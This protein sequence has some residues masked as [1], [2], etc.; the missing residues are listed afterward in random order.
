MS[1]TDHPESITYCFGQFA[2]NLAT[3]E[4]LHHGEAVELQ[5][6]VLDLLIYLLRNR[7]R[8]VDKQELQDAVWPRQIVTEAALTRCVMKARKALGDDAEQQRYIRTV[9]GTGYRLVT[10]VVET[11]QAAA[12]AR[13][14]LPPGSPPTLLR[15]AS[16]GPMWLSLL[17]IGIVL[18]VALIWL[19]QRQALEPT[20]DMSDAQIAIFPVT[21]ATGD[22]RYDWVTLGMMSSLGQ[23]LET[24]SRIRVVR[25]SQA[26]E[27]A[28][29]FHAG[30]GGDQ[31]LR[32]FAAEL[33][34]SDGI[35]LLVL[36][37]LEEIPGNL[38]IRYRIAR[39][40]GRIT[41]R[42]VV[43]SS[44]TDVARAAG[45]DLMVVL[46]LKLD[47]TPAS[48]DQFV[49]E[50]YIKGRALALQGELQA[51]REMF[52]IA[53]KHDPAAFWPRYEYALTLR[54]LGQREVAEAELRELIKL[55][56]AESDPDAFI[57]SRNALAILLWRRGE[58][59]EAVSLLNAALAVA[60]RDA[61]LTAAALIHSNLCILERIRGNLSA[62]REHGLLA[63]EVYARQ[64]IAKPPGNIF[65][66]LARVAMAEHDHASA[67]NH[68]R[69]AIE[70]FRT[71]GDRRATATTLNT[72]AS[73]QRQR[74]QWDLAQR[75]AEDGLALRIA[76]EDPV[77]EVA[78]REELAQIALSLDDLA[79]A[80]TQASRGLEI[81]AKLDLA[82]SQADFQR[83][84][85]RIDL[86]NGDLDQVPL[87]LQSAAES[88]QAV[89]EQAGLFRV[90]LLRIEWL[91][92]TGKSTQGAAQLDQLK[93]ANADDPDALAAI[94]SI[95]ARL[96]KGAGDHR[97]AAE[98]Y[99][100]AAEQ[101]DQARDQWA[102]ANFR[103]QAAIALL[104]DAQTEAAAQS[105]DAARLLQD[106]FLW[107]RTAA[108]IAFAAGDLSRALDLCKQA[109]ASAGAHW[110]DA[111]QRW[112]EQI[113]A[114]ASAQRAP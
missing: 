64:G 28:D 4:L 108:A 12:P 20:E 52:E 87:R 35:A 89:G 97:R 78:S 63:L 34:A 31:N 43:G 114:A 17:G 75:S 69:R 103:L 66:A 38:R 105:L 30:S 90:E 25:S 110:G 24:G 92:Q 95:E 11:R 86:A 40:S 62:A 96:A 79:T 94:A 91:A 93:D 81:A 51:A 6:K 106:Q 57:G 48:T 8:A 46:G 77:G 72:L 27:L 111:D 29:R 82:G 84:L 104:A 112:L 67:E 37:V 21:N 56:N 41:E 68:L 99:G 44:V 83:H 2:V 9:H 76:L 5:P 55:T 88:Y 100:Q 113:A 61:D 102:A 39:P 109:R 14:T 7:H 36:P 32:E 42:S 26:I 101:A 45:A 18:S 59:E 60:D 49:D 50:A 15:A 19:W 16:P 107:Q 98:A 10:D 71:V 73:L 65:H 58:H 22:A 70:A 80:R 23:V 3:R 54:D 85:A 33:G 1:Q 53:V 13:P 74:G 47:R